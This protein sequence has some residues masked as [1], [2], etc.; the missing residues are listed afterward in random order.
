MLGYLC[1]YYRYYYPLEFITAFLNNAANDEDVRNGTV[2]A[3]K[4]GISI[5]MPKWGISKDEYFF[6]KEKNIISKGLS[7][8][9]YMSKAIA[10]ELYNASKQGMYGSFIDVLDSAINTVRIDSRQLDILIRIDFFSDFGNQKELRTISDLYMD[11]FKKGTAKQVSRSKIEDDDLRGVIEKYSTG[12]TKAGGIAK[13]YTILDIWGAM[14]EAEQVILS[15]KMEDYTA[16]QKAINFNNAVG[17]VGY[18][19]GKE[20][21]RSSLQVADVYRLKSRAGRYFGYAITTKSIG[22]GIETRFSVSNP[23]YDR[24]PVKKG[25]IIKCKRWHRDGK[26]FCMDEYIKLN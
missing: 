7:S 11:V 21:D 8:I 9:K 14:Y 16:Q 1:A 15:R 17:Y 2:Y 22:S 3:N 10:E 5:T 13:S 24:V 23:M 19:S 6:D 4:K 12:T 25:D 18:V 20:E 26:Y